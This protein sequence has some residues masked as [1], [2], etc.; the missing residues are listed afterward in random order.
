MLAAPL[1]AGNDVRN[2]SAE[3]RGILTNRQVIALDQDPLGKQA[4]RFRM[5]A[6][7]EVWLKD[8]SGGQWAVCLLNTSASSARLKL[9]WRDLPF[10]ETQSYQVHD[11][12]A[13][14]NLGDPNTAFDGIVPSHDVALLR[15]TPL[16]SGSGQ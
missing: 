6:K 7:S 1:I 9:A 5:D 15:L 2:M 16:H 11:I 14:R 8:L 4:T 12:W 13:D 3:V 10:V